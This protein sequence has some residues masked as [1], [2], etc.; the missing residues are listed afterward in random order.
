MPTLHRAQ[1]T[2]EREATRF[3]VVDCGRRWGK[4]KYGVRKA[5]ETMLTGGRVGWFAP[6]YKVLDDAWSEIKDRLGGVTTRKDETDHLLEVMTGGVFEA[7]SLDKTEDAGRSRHYHRVIIDEAAMVP[8]LADVWQKAIRPTL[9][10]YRGDAFFFST[11]RGRNFFW[12]I[13]QRGQDPARG[14][15]AS[16]QFPTASN[17]YIHP[18]EI[19]AA[20]LDLPERSFSQEWL[21]E[22]LADPGGV[23]RGVRAC[24]TEQRRE[25]MRGL[26]VA[27]LDWGQSNDFTVMVV[28]DAERRRVVDMDRFNRLDWAFQ[29]GRVKALADKWG[30]S[31]IVAESNSIGGPNIEALQRDGLPVIGFETTA[32]S[33]PPLIESLALAFERREIAV[34]D[35]PVLVG[36]LEAYERDVSPVTG[37][38]RYSA[39]EGMHDDT[40]IALALA[41]HGATSGGR[42][43]TRRAA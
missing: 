4:T 13:W 26:F 7:W 21:A 38:S 24:A 29:R 34:L 11:P 23:F 33:K 8:N 35:D 27:G 39:P 42:S 3:N 18:D 32:T 15:W 28:L 31:L 37:R 41:W 16:W 25:P 20:R 40:V 30:V 5:C 43:R 17:P 10:D 22:F 1:M 12:E 2:V 36:E 6:T 19:E 14:D 9:A